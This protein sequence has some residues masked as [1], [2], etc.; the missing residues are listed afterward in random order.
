MRISFKA[1]EEAAGGF[2]GP[3]GGHNLVVKKFCQTL[4]KVGVAELV[5]PPAAEFLLLERKRTLLD[6]VV[7]AV[8][9]RRSQT[10]VLKTF[11][12]FS[13]DKIL[14]NL[15]LSL[16][17]FLPLKLTLFCRIFWPLENKE[18]SV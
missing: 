11:A 13:T 1:A 15:D 3:R 9:Y 14:I 6:W 7:E 18:K 8:K 4:L 5:A 12:C 2:L 16:K 17:K 10:L